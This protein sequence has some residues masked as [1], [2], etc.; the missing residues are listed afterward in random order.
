MLCRKK[1]PLLTGLEVSS[2]ACKCVFYRREHNAKGGG[3][4]WNWIQKWKIPTDRA[5]SV[6]GKNRVICRIIM[7]STQVRIIKM[8]KMAAF[9]IFLLMPA[10]NQSQFEQNIYMHLKDLTYNSQKMLGIVGF[11][12]TISKISTLEYSDSLFFA[13]SAVFWY[14]HPWYLKNSKSKTYE[15]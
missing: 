6:D 9:C 7:F 4:P 1:M 14:L 10:T 3:T 12:G 8:L 2:L 5:H 15:P 11:W 13:D